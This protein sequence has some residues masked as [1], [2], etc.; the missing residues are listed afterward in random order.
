MRTNRCLIIKELA[1][2]GGISAGSYYEILTA[3]FKMHCVAA[4]FVSRLITDNQRANRIRICQELLDRS[5]ED[6]N[7]L[8]R[9][10]TGDES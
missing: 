10:I 3:K 1:E 6:E 4:E 5:D 7:F 8:S 9:I 2:E